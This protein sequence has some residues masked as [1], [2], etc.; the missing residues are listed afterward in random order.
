M[1]LK[2]SEIPYNSVPFNEY[3]KRIDAT[4]IKISF[5]NKRLFLSDIN[6]QL[7]TTVLFSK[8][9]I[10]EFTI[11]ELLFKGSSDK[12]RLLYYVYEN[13]FENQNWLW[14]LEVIDIDSL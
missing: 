12:V 5:S 4:Y 13:G 1:S 10:K 14:A 2:N 9:I 8:S 7:I 6:N 3:F 11:D